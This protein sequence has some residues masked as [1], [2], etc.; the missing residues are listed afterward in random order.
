MPTTT[1]KLLFLAAS[2]SSLGALAV[3][4]VILA[5]QQWVSTTLRCHM[6]TANS[7]F[8]GTIDMQYGLFQGQGRDGCALG[9]NRQ[10]QVTNYLRSSANLQAVHIIVIFSLII[11]LVCS[12]ASSI[13]TMNNI[14]N[15]PSETFC[16]PIGLYTW[17][18]ISCVLSTLGMVLFALNAEVYELSLHLAKEHATQSQDTVLHSVT[19]SYGYSF[20]ITF[21]VIALNITTIFIAFAYEHRSYNRKQEQQIPIENA[22]KDVL[23]Y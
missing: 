3:V 22:P 16:G 8:N 10:F 20:W 18:G 12:A 15:N 9:T 19:D 4:C 11:C 17:N 2:I 13:T 6:T 14:G 7:S 5:T 23:M 1:K 21:V